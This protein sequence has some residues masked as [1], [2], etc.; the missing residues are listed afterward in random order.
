MT[1]A[2]S[3]STATTRPG[4]LSAASGPGLPRGLGQRPFIHANMALDAGGRSTVGDGGGDSL[5]CPRDWCR[6]HELRER[7]TGVVVGA[8][9][10][11]L[12]QPRLTAREECLGRPP[13]RQPDRV[14]FAGNT[15]CLVE[16]E[17]RRTFVVGS[18][19]QPEG[20][21]HITTTRHELG[22]PLS[23]LYRHGV[24]TLLV[25]GGLTLLRSFVREGFVDRLTIYVRTRSSEQ[26]TTALRS[27]L[28]EFAGNR[29]QADPLGLGI[30]M[31]CESG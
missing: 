21:I 4:A 3:M 24:E 20:V 12:D 9:T 26:A 30:L 16:R 17:Q 19:E 8:R 22:L 13:R 6:V 14:I 18:E 15:L 11:L 31:T 25:E 7:Y 27:A 28:P 5:S 29:L 23:E 1:V 2:P 10:W